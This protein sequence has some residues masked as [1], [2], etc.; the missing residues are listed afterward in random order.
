[1]R[2][3][4]LEIDGR[5]L[6][7]SFFDP[8]TGN[9]I[10]KVEDYTERSSYLG[11]STTRDRVPYKIQQKVRDRFTGRYDSVPSPSPELVDVSITDRCSFGCSYCY[12]DSTAKGFHAP[13]ELIPTLLQGFETVPYQIAIGGGEPTGHPDFPWILQ[14]ARKLGTVPNYT[15]AGHVF[16]KAVIEATNEYCGGVALTYHAFKGFEWF[17]STYKK[18]RNALTCQLNVHLI[19]DKDVAQNLYDLCKLQEKLK[20]PLNLVLLAY[21]PDVGRATLDTMM[22]RTVYSRKLPDMITLAKAKGMRIAFSEGLL[23]FFLSRPEIDINTDLASRSEGLFS[24]YVGPQ[25]HMSASSFDER[26]QTE[27]T[28]YKVKAQKLWEKLYNYGTPNGEPC[29]DCEFRNRCATPSQFHYL[30]CAYASHN[31]LPLAPVPVKS[32]YDHVLEDD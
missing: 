27:D 21:Y 8:K 4:R 14:Q 15:T 20:E 28:I 10:R 30:T 13:P 19:A 12:Q 23:P 5:L 17:E 1:M 6:Y 3:M 31:K 25:G 2:K 16:K 22:T 32:R 26:T 24:C 7:E 29:Y 9:T 18:W 11:F